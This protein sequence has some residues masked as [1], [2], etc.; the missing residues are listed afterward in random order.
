MDLKLR[1]A[2]YLLLCSGGVLWG[3]LIK[4]EKKKSCNVS[5]ELKTI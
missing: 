3:D 2:V 4:K 5:V 1:L